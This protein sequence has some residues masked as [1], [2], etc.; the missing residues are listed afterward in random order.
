MFSDSPELF[1]TAAHECPYLSDRKAVNLLV[2]P[3]YP[4]DVATYGRLLNKG[5][6]RSG[7]DVYRPCCYRCHACISTRIP[8]KRFQPS[9]SQR[10]TWKRNQDLQVVVNHQGYKK[11]YTPLY[12]NYIRSR[13]AGGGMDEDSPASFANFILTAWCDTVLL[14][15]WEGAHL[16]GVAVTDRMAQGLSSV[17]TFFDPDRGSLRGIGTFALMWQIH[18][19]QQLGLFYVYPGYWIAESP[20]MN[21]KARFQPIEGL[22]DNDWV[23]L[24]SSSLG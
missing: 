24:P 16:L 21:Y 2:D 9:R 20:K 10:R 17:Y 3:A 6:R 7:T 4:M 15:F 22:I 23:L 18:W 11:I 19:A 13:H 14:E 5:F 12:L 8:V 1:I